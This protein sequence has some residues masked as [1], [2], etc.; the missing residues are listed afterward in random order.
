MN[1]TAALG[2]GIDGEA[3]AKLDAFEALLRRWNK[4]YSLVSRG[5]IARL[6]QRH[7]HDSLALLPWWTGSLADVG[8]G[9]GFPG[10]PLAIA[11]PQSPVAL[12]ERSEGKSRFLRQVLIELQLANVELVVADVGDYRPAALFD[13]VTV[14]AVA[15]PKIAWRLVRRLAKPETGTVLLQSRDPLPAETFEGG[16]ASPAERCGIGWVT[17][18]R[19]HRLDAA[20]G[21]DQHGG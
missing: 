18:V 4:R 3:A 8:S 13:T 12:I 1:Q 5:D 14:R 11:R 19:R 20:A 7:V 16:L 6:R 10:L 17:P 9:G 15:A 21:I 2:Q